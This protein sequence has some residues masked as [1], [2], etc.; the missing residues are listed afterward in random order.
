MNI[1][2]HLNKDKY[3]ILI[4]SFLLSCGIVAFFP[5][6]QDTSVYRDTIRIHVIANSDSIP[7]QNLKL[8]VRDRVI[9][10]ANTLIK[11]CNSK[12]EAVDILS[13]NITIL[14]KTA[15]DAQKKYGYLYNITAT[16][17]P[18]YYPTRNYENFRLPEGKYTSLKIN[19]GK[20]QGQNWW[21][22]IYPSFCLKPAVK[23]IP[24]IADTSPN[25]RY[26]IK[27][28]ILEWFSKISQVAESS[29]T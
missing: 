3:L 21:C 18:E 24:N 9:E 27:F 28:K 26:K 17:S 6:S 15:Y 11:N 4:F 14:E 16:I 7:D 1:F 29:A 20:A 12:N 25:V 10:T 8:I 2:K 13:K 22:V 19:I 5:C 23:N